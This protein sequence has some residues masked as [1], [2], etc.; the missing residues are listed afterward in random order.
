MEAGKY[1][2]DISKID[3]LN[4]DKSSVVI[5]YLPL[6]YFS[7]EWRWM[8][9]QLKTK[10]RSAVKCPIVILPDSF[11]V[12]KIPEGDYKIHRPGKI[13]LRD[14]VL[15]FFSIVTTLIIVG[16]FF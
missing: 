2:I 9:N 12:E 3:S 16:L 6:K 14:I 10:V 15:S 8:H 13:H 4:I 1:E 5:V 11:R 7:E